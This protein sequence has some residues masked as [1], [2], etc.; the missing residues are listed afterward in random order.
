MGIRNWSVAVSRGLAVVAATMMFSGAVGE[1]LSKPVQI[2]P[3]RF[4]V[5]DPKVRPGGEDFWFSLGPGEDGDALLGLSADHK[6]HD[7]PGTVVV[8]GG[9][10]AE[11]GSLHAGGVLALQAKYWAEGN[12]D[13]DLNFRFQVVP[14]SRTPTG[15]LSLSVDHESPRPTKQELFRWCDDGPALIMDGRVWPVRMGPPDSGGPGKRA[16][17]IPN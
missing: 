8:G 9:R 3:T 16:L 12:G 6:G 13:N 7:V 5:L 10:M 17:V 14:T 4:R 2:T 11:I 1:E 15:C